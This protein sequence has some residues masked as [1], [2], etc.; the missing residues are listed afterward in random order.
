MTLVNVVPHV[1]LHQK[2]H[3]LGAENFLG[4]SNG[5]PAPCDRNWNINMQINFQKKN[6]HFRE[7]YKMVITVY[8]R[9]YQKTELNLCG[10]IFCTEFRVDSESGLKIDLGGRISELHLNLSW[11]YTSQLNLGSK[12]NPLVFEAFNKKKC[13]NFSPSVPFWYTWMCALALGV[14]WI[15]I[16]WS[17]FEF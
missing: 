10:D 9:L 4:R 6:H 17:T 7:L 8:T 14:Y 1:V 12:I 16:I 3:V 11:G 13:V 2:T 15:I 5:V